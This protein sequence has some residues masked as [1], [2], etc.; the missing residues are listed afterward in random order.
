[1]LMVNRITKVLNNLCYCHL[2]IFGNVETQ[3]DTT[4]LLRLDDIASN[5]SFDKKAERFFT[6][7]LTLLVTSDCT[8]EYIINLI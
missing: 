8:L 5:S 1:M 7:L 2:Y 4:H 6:Y 3:I